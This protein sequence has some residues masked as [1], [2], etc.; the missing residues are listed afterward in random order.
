MLTNH[1]CFF[2]WKEFLKIFLKQPMAFGVILFPFRNSSCHD[3]SGIS[4]PKAI[5]HL[6]VKIYFKSSKL[7]LPMIFFF[8]LFLIKNNFFPLLWL[9]EIYKGTTFS[10]L[11]FASKPFSLASPQ[12]PQPRSMMIHWSPVQKFQIV[13]AASLDHICQI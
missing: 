4:L 8:H 10:P 3:M 11:S 2:I 7:N 5:P 12:S 9:F 6:C 1:K 13:L